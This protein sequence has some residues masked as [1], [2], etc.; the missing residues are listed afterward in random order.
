MSE[1]KKYTVMLLA[2]CAVLV[3][4][5]AMI[6]RRSGEPSEPAE[7]VPFMTAEAELPSET[8][9]AAPETTASGTAA[10]EAE[11]ETETEPETTTETAV[12]A[13]LSTNG[14]MYIEKPHIYLRINHIKDIP[15]KLGGGLAKSQIEWSTDN[16]DIVDVKDGSVVG[17]TQ[18]ECNIIASC[19]DDVLV[20]PVTVRELSVVDGCTY[21]D[22]ILVANKSYSLPEDYDP[23]TLPITK[24]AF[25]ALVQDAAAEGLNIYEGSAYRDYN[26]QVT[27]YNSMVRGYS[28][29]YADAYSA[30]PGHSEHQTGY[31]ID[32]NTI[33]DR[34]GETA[35]GKWLAAHCHE[36]GFI[37]RYPK[38]KEDITGYAYESWHIR[39]VGVEHA[40]TIYEQGLT[41]EE[42]LD[43]DSA[44]PGEDNN[45]VT[46]DAHDNE[47]NEE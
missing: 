11:T 38:G 40:T 29:E 2:L 28:K 1:R 42:Y 34:F 13:N 17:L 35:E 36:Y 25:E 45:S 43:I 22:G 31:T 37:I 46:Q 30:R 3:F 32:C 41:L 16:E 33:D 8:E 23:G 6:V 15:V 4:G 7:P 14:N 44:Y 24:E 47:D 18:G 5:V 12:Q 21:V 20:I 39:Y 26:F 10:T 19:G 9:T 27:V